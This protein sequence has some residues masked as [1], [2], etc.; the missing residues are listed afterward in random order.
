MLN[1]S[2]AQNISD[3]LQQVNAIIRQQLDS[4]I[5]LINIISDYLLSAGG[6]RLRPIAMLLVGK[7]LNCDDPRLH[8]AAAVVEFLHTSTLLH[9]DV[10][11]ASNQRRGRPTVNANWGNPQAVLVG[12]F[13]Y[14]KSF[15]MLVNIQDLAVMQVMANA[16]R[17]LA[18]GEVLQLTQINNANIDEA[19]YLDIIQSKTAILFAAAAQS[20]AILSTNNTQ[21]IEQIRKFGNALGIAFQIIDDLLDYQS[22]STI[23]G[24]NI[25]DDLAEGKPTLPLIYALQNSNKQQRVIIEAAI[26][27]KNADFA[28]ILHIITNTKALQKTYDLAQQ[29]ID[30]A[31]SYLANVP[32]NCYKS[33]LLKLIHF[34]IR[35]TN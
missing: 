6:K 4:R 29:Y 19:T 2:F 18:E 16:T 22:D 11:D 32:N 24:K 15:E 26:Q 9:D 13:L 5:E 28:E 35:R 12:D 10:V 17:T 34:A 25:G 31:K 21:Q 8:Q 33:D 27:Q 30:Q 20:A 23:L 1:L 3:D 14:A 7:A